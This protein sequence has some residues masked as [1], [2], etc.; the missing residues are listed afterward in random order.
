MTEYERMVEWGNHATREERQ[1]EI[2]QAIARVD[3]GEYALLT[4]SDVAWP[5]TYGALQLTQ[6]S[7]K[8]DLDL[9][10][11]AWD[12]EQPHRGTT[13]EQ[14]LMAD[15]V[16]A[17]EEAYQTV[18]NLDGKIAYDPDIEYDLE[19]EDHCWILSQ[20]QTLIDAHRAWKLL[21]LL[22]MDYERPVFPWLEWTLNSRED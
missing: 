17:Q 11:K 4:I 18:L 20:Q 3:E 21:N 10:A 8:L 13:T 15:T 1:A 2:A 9:M 19:R 22:L 5:M 6:A 7:M 16:A 14:A 12:I